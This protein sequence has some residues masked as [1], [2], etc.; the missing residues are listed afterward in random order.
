MKKIFRKIQYQHVLL[1]AILLLGLVLRVRNYTLYP[2]RGASS[3]EYTYTF[4]GMSLLK[5]GVP[6]TWSNFQAYEKYGKRQNLT[7]DNIYFPLVTPY[8][9]HPPLNGILTGGWALLR[10]EDTFQKVTTSTIRQVPI[11]LSVISA[12]LLY[13]IAKKF[14]DTKTALWS[15]LIYST[16][17]IIVMQTRFVFAE[18]LITPLFLGALLIFYNLKKNPKL[19][20]VILMGILSGL[21]FW[22]KELGVAVFLSILTLQILEKWSLKQILIFS[23]VS[24]FIFLLYPLY[25]YYYNWNLFYAVVFTQGA[26]EI[27]PN[28][29]NTLFFDP[30]IVNK[31]YFDGWYLFGFVSYFSS[32]LDLER[33]KKILVPA[34]IY[35]FLM[36]F[37]LTSHGEMG[38][39]MLPMF[40]FFC[41]LSADLLNTNIKKGNGYIFIT[42]LFVGFYIVRYYYQAKFGLPNPIFRGILLA[43]FGPL[44]VSYILRKKVLFQR[45]S[46]I[47]FYALIVMTIYITW[48]YQHPQ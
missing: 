4:M 24:V 29:L 48:Y 39:Y 10:G 41:I 23:A 16:S 12:L 44:F 32:F 20:K 33:Y 9:D 36:L 2:P 13:F 31:Q 25:G 45:L 5:T 3:D 30:I 14:F 28:T 42:A 15:I 40:P 43:G 34:S 46:E 35:F 7:I 21:A 37:S 18:N 6:T 26:R 8:F 17:T 11:F 38:W 1:V 19:W 22:A 47:G 27:G